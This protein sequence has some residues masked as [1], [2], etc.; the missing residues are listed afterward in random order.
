LPDVLAVEHAGW[1]ARGL[2]QQPPFL[3]HRKSHVRLIFTRLRYGEDARDAP[4]GLLKRSA[5]DKI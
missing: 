1:S 5:Q 3:T 2:D 4:H